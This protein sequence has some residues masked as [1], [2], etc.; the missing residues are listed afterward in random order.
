MKVPALDRSVKSGKP[1]FDLRARVGTLTATVTASLAAMRSLACTWQP[2]EGKATLEPEGLPAA[3]ATRL[4]LGNMVLEGSDGF[5]FHR[6]HEAI[7]QVTGALTYSPAQLQQ[8]LSI[9]E[10]RKA[11][12]DAHGIV[13]RF[14]IVPEK[15]VVY[16]DK[17]PGG[18]VISEQRP[19]PMLM[20]AATPYL[21]GHILYP[22]E[23]LQDAR[24]RRETHWITDT[25]WNMFGAFVAYKELMASLARDIDLVQLE[26]TDLAT[27]TLTY[28]GDLGVRFEPE[29]SETI[30]VLARGFGPGC[31]LVVQN[32]K[33]DRGNVQVFTNGR[34]DMPTCVLLRDSFAGSLI[35]LLLESFSRLVAVSSLSMLYDLVRAERPDV[36]VVQMAERFLGTHWTGKEI[37][38][39]QDLGSPTFSEFTGVDLEALRGA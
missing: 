10:T 2:R 7:E 28:V 3:L 8:W 9:L 26:E 33:F 32:N 27:T 4:R 20:R 6:D 23:P 17:L 34:A 5:L 25:H 18:I 36:V 30:E 14:L 22:L 15:H 13:S 24:L 38:M 16:A 37:L 39:P 29:R 11:W 19:A 12:C 1:S 35:P 21:S 31:K